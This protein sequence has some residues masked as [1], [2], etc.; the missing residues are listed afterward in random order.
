M[1]KLMC[2]FTIENL[3]TIANRKSLKSLLF[4]PSK[5]TR[6]QQWIGVSSRV[7][8]DMYAHTDM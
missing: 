2:I 5:E 3:E 7:D 1:E 6:C 8:R 4:L